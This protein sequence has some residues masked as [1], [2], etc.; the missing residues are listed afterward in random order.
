MRT[1][2]ASVIVER[3]ARSADERSGDGAAG[4]RGRHRA[5]G[6]T[7]CGRDTRLLSARARTA[8]RYAPDA[9]LLL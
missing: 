1:R 7:N 9:G 3:F 2:E 6:R 5:M 4:S 8:I